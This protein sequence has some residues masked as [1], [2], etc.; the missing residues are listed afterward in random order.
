MLLKIFKINER[1]ILIIENSFLSI[2]LFKFLKRNSIT[3]IDFNKFLKT[4]ETKL[5]NITI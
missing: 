5:S 3:T 1:N 4:K 2:N